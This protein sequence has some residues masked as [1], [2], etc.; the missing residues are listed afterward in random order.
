MLYEELSRKAKKPFFVARSHFDVAVAAKGEAEARAIITPHI[1]QQLHA[2]DDSPIY[3]ISSVGLNH[4][5]LEKLILA[6]RRELPE[7]KQVRFIMAAQAYGE[8]TLAQKRE[9]AEK[10]VGIHAGLAAANALNPIPGLDIS[11]DLGILATMNRYVISTYGLTQDQIQAMKNQ[12]QICA[13]VMRGLQEVA[14]RF[15]PYL[16]ESFPGHGTEE[17]GHGSVG[18]Q[19][20]QVGAVRRHTDL[21]WCGFQADISP[22][23]EID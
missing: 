16:T 8:E 5:D 20:F 4:Y 15:T 21:S 12:A 9:A 22:G 23:R 2:P 6:V 19:L 3:L 17:H 13:T 11:V 18:A 10:I 14:D 7:W 1:R